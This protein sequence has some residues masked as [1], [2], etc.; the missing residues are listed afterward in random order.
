MHLVE[1]MRQDLN[2][3]ETAMLDTARRKQPHRV[4]ALEAAF[5]MSPGNKHHLPVFTI[6][7]GDGETYRK[8][9][10]KIDWSDGQEDS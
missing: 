7:I 6:T 8:N 10:E 9:F 3:T 4:Q 5:G 2:E 1:T